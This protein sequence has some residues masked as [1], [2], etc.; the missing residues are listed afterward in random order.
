MKKVLKKTA[1]L[2]ALAPLAI[3]C[4]H[5]NPLDNQSKIAIAKKSSVI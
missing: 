2:L 3:T 4:S 1:F 5:A